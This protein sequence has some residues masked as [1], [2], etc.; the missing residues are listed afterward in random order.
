MHVC[1]ESDLVLTMNAP[2]LIDESIDTVEID[3]KIIGTLEEYLYV[4]VFTI[5]E[6]LID[7]AQGGVS[8]VLSI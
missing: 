5:S 1:F 2:D 3:V 4:R 6:M 8:T 7:S